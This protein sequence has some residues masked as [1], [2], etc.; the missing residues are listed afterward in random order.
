M[1]TK[2]VSQ[3]IERAR[4]LLLDADPDGDYRSNDPELLQ[5]VQEGHSFIVIVKPNANVA[6]TSVQ[7]QPGTRQELP[8]GAIGLVQ[9]YNNMGSSG[10][11]PG[12]VITIVDRQTLDNTD[13]GWPQLR[14]MRRL[15]TMYMMR[16]TLLILMF[17]PLSLTLRGM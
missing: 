9:V 15:F 16:M 7:L 13:P 10:N 4:I 8:A 12:S 2:L 3:V 14:Q 17:I 11:T 1:A 5:W 6:N